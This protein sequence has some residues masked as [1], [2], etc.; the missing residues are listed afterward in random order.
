M[1][2]AEPMPYGLAEMAGPRSPLEVQVDQGN[3]RRS[4]PGGQGT[5]EI[6]NS[7]GPKPLHERGHVLLFKVKATLGSPSRR[8][9]ERAPIQCSIKPLKY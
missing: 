3:V 6:K 8:L 1:R 2:R 5:G 9:F 7:S 4:A